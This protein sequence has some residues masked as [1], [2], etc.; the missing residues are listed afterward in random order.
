MS[1]D[2]IEFVKVVG[3]PGA[4]LFGLLWVLYKVLIFISKQIL[5]P[6]AD[7]H[8]KFLD[9]VDAKS[10]RQTVAVEQLATS[11][12]EHTATNKEVADKLGEI[13]DKIGEVKQLVIKTGQVVI[14]P[15]VPKK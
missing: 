12:K 6:L 3:L 10:E 11:N 8:M 5:L 1:A 4:V 2:V 15:E 14:A 13:A 9:Q 7:R